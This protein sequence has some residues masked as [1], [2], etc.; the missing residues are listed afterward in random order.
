MIFS[1]F[2]CHVKCLQMRR[3][4]CSGRRRH[5]RNKGVTRHSEW[6]Y[7]LTRRNDQYDEHDE[8]S[9]PPVC[10]FLFVCGG[11]E[12]F[13]MTLNIISSFFSMSRIEHVLFLNIETISPYEN[14]EV[15]HL[16]SFDISLH[17]LSPL[18]H[19]AGQTSSRRY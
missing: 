19:F 18:I 9:S 10:L 14:K 12:R 7:T 5:K 6:S 3:I 8:H 17:N 4:F 2:Q 15:N 13:G 1:E 11:F 16:I